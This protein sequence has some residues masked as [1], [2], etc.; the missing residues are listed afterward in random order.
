M[1]SACRARQVCLQ[2][3][4]LQLD[5]MAHGRVP[6]TEQQDN[7]TSIL[8]LQSPNAFRRTFG[9]S[10]INEKMH[11]LLAENVLKDVSQAFAREN[12]CCYMLFC[13]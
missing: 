5:R 1:V 4:E 9:M 3:L 11:L 13:D 2:L 6:N 12:G 8:Q 7:W 10:H